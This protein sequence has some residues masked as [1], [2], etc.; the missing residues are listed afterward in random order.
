[1]FG[2][3]YDQQPISNSEAQSLLTQWVDSLE[4]AGKKVLVL[5]PDGTRTAPIPFFFEALNTLLASRVQSLTYLI[6][7]GTHPPMQPDSITRLVGMTE[8]AWQARWPN[9]NVVN[10]DWQNPS[11]LGVIG[12]LTAAE[13]LDLSGGLLSIDI[14][15]QINRL[16]MQHDLCIVCG[17][18][19]PH[20]VVGFSGGAKYLFPGVGGQDI[21]N[22]THWLGALVTSFRTIGIPDT[23]VR[24][25]IHAAANRLATPTACIA[26]VM[27]GSH[28]HGL[29]LGEMREAWQAAAGLSGRLNIITVPQPFHTVLSCPPEM[30]DELWTAAKAAYKTEPAVADGGEI[31]IYAPH[32]KEISLVHGHYIRQVGYHVIEYFL[33]QMDR[34]KDV[35]QGVLAHSTHVRGLGAYKDGIEKPRINVTLATG[36]PRE[37][38]ELVNLGY[39]DPASINLS[40][41]I[42]REHEGILYVPH[43]GEQL[44][45]CPQLL[46]S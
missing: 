36:I 26:F 39:R 46:R 31:I 25:V 2:L 9:V 5:I 10:H 20:E 24:R 11:A 44:Y 21:I 18:V 19:F 42:N 22:R 37:T 23:P 30:Y 45:R 29:F 32:L 12:T 35:P 15:I 4:W 6:A 43:A 7:L 28:M 8:S 40:D 13:V 14:P 17:P 27:Q 16:V 33:K 3:G 34:F 38:C 41:Y 1:V